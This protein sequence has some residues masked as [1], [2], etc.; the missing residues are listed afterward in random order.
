M[1]IVFI[2]QNMPAQFKHVATRLA[3]DGA[4]HVKFMTRRRD[5]ELPGV[6]RVSYLPPPTPT[7][8]GHRFLQRTEGAIL[9]GEA[10]A[11]ALRQLKAEGLRPDLICGHPGWGE[12]LFV[13]DV[14]PDTP[15][16]SYCELY[17]QPSGQ[18]LGFD[19]RQAPP[20]DVIYQS[21]VRNS[22]LLL[23]A[24]ACDAGI[25]PTRWQRQGFPEAFQSKI[26]VIHDGIDAGTFRPD[27]E[28]TFTLPSGQVLSRDDEVVTYVSRGLEPIRGFEVFMEA[29][30]R[31]C[32]ARP[33]AHVLVVGGDE[34]VYGFPTGTGRSW[35]EEMLRRVPVDPARVHFLGT[36]PYDTYRQVLQVSTAHV[37]LTFPFVLSWS[38]L[39][40]MST[41]CV[42]VG[43]RTAPVVEVLEDGRNGLLVDFWSPTE[44]ADRVVDVLRDRRAFASLGQAARDTIL[45]RFEVEDCLSRQMALIGRLTA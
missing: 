18:E 31:I 1:E 8:A 9:F 13:K 43:S 25:S 35:R 38:M 12:L 26:E 29:L 45:D 44:V 28:A 21:R 5:R 17:H 40:A 3:R 16:L 33:Q 20:E 11:K 39:E 7:G 42:L 15:L 19:P 14:F 32:A 23:S 37:Y 4:N 41:G 27:P 24:E 36:L 10:V 22:H 30:P 34:V 6:Q 2:H